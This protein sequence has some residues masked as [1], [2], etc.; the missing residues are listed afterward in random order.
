[1]NDYL[2]NVVNNVEDAVKI[3]IDPSKI[4]TTTQV[5]KIFQT[6][7]RTIAY[8]FNKGYIKGFRIPGSKH[9]R[10]LGNSL[11]EFIKENG[12][13]EYLTEK[14]YTTG[15]AAK[16]CM[17]SLSNIIKCFDKKI[18]KGYRIHSTSDR[19]IPE[20]CL[21]KFMKENEMYEYLKDNFNKK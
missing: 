13:Y 6:S 21:I 4:Y 20:K 9:R 18:L 5:A 3:E 10:I 14:T 15:E 19:R 11:I 2:E 7:P 1:M 12:M 8:L 16:L 17:V